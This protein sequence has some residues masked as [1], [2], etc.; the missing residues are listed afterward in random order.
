MTAVDGPTVSRPAFPH[1]IAAVVLAAGLSSRMGGRPKG[2]LRFDDRDTFVSRIVRTFNEAG[3]GEVVVVV[4]HQGDAVALEVEQSGLPARI[5]RNE[6]YLQGQFT[7]VIA[8]VDAVDRDGVEGLLLA[9]VDAPA[10]S[11]ET[12]RALVERFEQTHAPVVRAVRGP[13]HGHPV[14]LGR[15]LCDALRHAD[16]SSGAKPIVRAHVSH[17]GDVEVNDEGAFVDVDTPAEY[18]ELPRLL[19]RLRARA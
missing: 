17:E 12:V 6:R 8:G 14:L 16:P 3:V 9:L 4:G 13:L 7:S 10:F 15:V 1:M 11:A 2:L 18:A 19:A 5:V